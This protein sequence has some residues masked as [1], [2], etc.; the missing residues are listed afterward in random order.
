MNIMV[1][2]ESLMDCISQ[3]DGSLRPLIGG[4]PY[5][6][7]RAASLQGAA[8]GYLNPTSTDVFGGQLRSQLLA[9]GVA[10]VGA[11]SPLP[12]SLAVV[13][14]REGQPSYGFYREGIADR[15]YTATEIF[16][17]LRALKPGIL[18][19]G[20]LMLIPPESD[21]VL[22]V[23]A[24]AKDMGWTISIDVNM[25]PS[26]APDLPSYVAAVKSVAALADWLKASDEDLEI[27][28]FDTCTREHAPTMATHFLGQGTSRVALTYGGDGA[29]L[30]VDAQ[31][32]HADVPV[33]TI[34]DT[35]GAGDTFWGNCLAL[36]SAMTEA[37][38]QDQVAQTL[39]HAMRAAAINCTRQGCNPPT[40]EEVL[41]TI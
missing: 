41:A 37:Q 27:L 21:K 18:H 33:V 3:P 19:T 36:W 15:D 32:A 40:R 12:T 39:R 25:R 22:A 2:G 5:N 34:A 17:S 9:D 7:A 20:S 4:S 14:V 38:A 24:G 31:A 1:L 28:G 13:N 26:V 16:E 8:V 29:Y 30:A 6:L 23:L 35:V 11:P 10:L